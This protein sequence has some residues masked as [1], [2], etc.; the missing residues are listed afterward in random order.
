MIPNEGQSMKAFTRLVP[1]LMLA[2][3]SAG[4]N[5]TGNVR[6]NNGE[7]VPNAAIDQSHPRAAL[8]LGSDDM[9]GTLNIGGLRF[10][11]VG[12]LSQAQV[13][14]QNL[15]NDNF[16]LEYRFE[17]QDRDGF[18]IDSLGTWHR[19]KLAAHGA[20][21]FSS[22]GKTPEAYKFVFTVRYPG[23]PFIRM[24]RDQDVRDEEERRYHHG[25]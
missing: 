13:T 6:P 2:A 11:Q 10:R 21:S 7:L 3:M 14:V 9:I 5:E 19:F 18:N 17:W 15:T 4:C 24:D 20:K 23:G 16:S 8:I 1:L 22:T 12:Q 25:H